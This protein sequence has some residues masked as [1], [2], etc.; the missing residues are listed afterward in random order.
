MQEGELVETMPSLPANPYGLAKDTLMKQLVELNK[1][2]PFSLKWPRLFYMY[3]VGH[4]DR[5]YG[6]GLRSGERREAWRG[7]APVRATTEEATA[8]GVSFVE[9][10]LSLRQVD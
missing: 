10:L 9:R 5:L 7:L 3:G 4:W 2:Y 6:A 1:F 8:A